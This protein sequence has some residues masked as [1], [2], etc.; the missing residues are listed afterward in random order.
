MTRL[1]LCGWCLAAPGCTPP[2]VHRFP[3]T[4]PCDHPKHDPTP[5]TDTKETP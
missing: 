5:R 4:C 2:H 3:T 1:S